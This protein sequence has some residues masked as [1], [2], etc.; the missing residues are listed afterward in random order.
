MKKYTNHRILLAGMW[1]VQP[2]WKSIW[3]FF[4]WLCD[5]FLLLGFFFLNKLKIQLWEDM[6]LELL[7]IYSR[8]EDSCSHKTCIWMDIAG[9]FIIAPN[10][11]QPRWPSMDGLCKVRAAYILFLMK[12]PNLPPQENT[13]IMDTSLETSDKPCRK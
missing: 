12:P 13:P 7:D 6:E 10:G 11:K 8:D 9:S 1:N 4:A 3:K 5:L 2:L